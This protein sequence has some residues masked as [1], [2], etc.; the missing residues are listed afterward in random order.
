MTVTG[1]RREFVS[2]LKA[3]LPGSAGV[4]PHSRYSVGI[5]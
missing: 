2:A 3:E 4:S 5:A 1:T